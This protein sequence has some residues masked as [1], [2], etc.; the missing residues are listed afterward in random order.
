MFLSGPI[1]ILG[2]ASA[3]GQGRLHLLAKNRP[4]GCVPTHEVI[5]L[6]FFATIFTSTS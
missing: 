1:D 2:G 6:A 5:I 3:P 4:T